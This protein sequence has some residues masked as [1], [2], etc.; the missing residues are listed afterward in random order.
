MAKTLPI[1]VVIPTF[2]REDV[3]LDTVSYLLALPAVAAE[4]LLIDQTEKHDAATEKRLDEMQRAGHIRR[5]QLDIPSIPQAMNRGLL[6]AKENL[7]LFLDDDIRPEPDLISA[8]HAAH[9]V[10]AKAL[11]A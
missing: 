2:R 3:L 4:I 10:H 9:A 5:I 1:S 11:I 6:E 8:H 7:V